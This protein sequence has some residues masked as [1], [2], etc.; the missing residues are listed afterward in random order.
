[1]GFRQKPKESTVEKL[2]KNQKIYIYTYNFL[3]RRAKIWEGRCRRASRARTGVKALVQGVI[4]PR[5][6]GWVLVHANEDRVRRCRASSQRSRPGLGLETE[7]TLS[8]RG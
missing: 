5:C 4:P 6:T 1:M 2:N 3:R 8:A 7:A